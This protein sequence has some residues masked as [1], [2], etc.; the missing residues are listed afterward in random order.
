MRGS[1]EKTRGQLKVVSFWILHSRHSVG[2][3]PPIKR[4]CPHCPRKAQAHSNTKQTAKNHSR[5]RSNFTLNPAFLIFAWR[6]SLNVSCHRHESL[7][8]SSFA[9]FCFCIVIPL[10]DGQ[11]YPPICFFAFDTTGRVEE[12][13][14]QWATKGMIYIFI[15]GVICSTLA[16]NCLKGRLG[17]YTTAPRRDVQRHALVRG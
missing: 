9:A 17:S 12:K 6:C 15:D 14:K 3:P 5:T 2:D 13:K 16:G 4:T 7:H 11:S 1:E 8:S 10:P